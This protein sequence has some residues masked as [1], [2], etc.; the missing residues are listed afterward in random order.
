MLSSAGLAHLSVCGAPSEM[1]GG[2][3]GVPEGES[4]EQTPARLR[5]VRWALLILL[6]FLLLILLLS[7][8]MLSSDLPSNF[9]NTTGLY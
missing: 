8:I 3:A 4:A 9:V 7:L 1:S 5:S 6:L 2:A